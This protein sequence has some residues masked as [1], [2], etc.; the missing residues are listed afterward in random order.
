MS[1]Y[2]KV[3]KLATEEG[4]YAPGI[5]ARVR[6]LSKDP[7][8]KELPAD[9]RGRAI[10]R[11]LDSEGL[12]S[13]SKAMRGLLESETNAQGED[14]DNPVRFGLKDIAKALGYGENTGEMLDSGHGWE[15]IPYSRYKSKFGDDADAVRSILRSATHDYFQNEKTPKARSEAM[16]DGSGLGWL[17][18]FMFPRAAEA[19]L[20]GEDPSISKDFALDAAEIALSLVPFGKAGALLGRIP[21]IGEMFAKI[22]GVPLAGA[23]A[24]RLP[25]AAF[26]PVTTGALDA[27]AYDGEGRGTFSPSSALEATAFN[28][29]VPWVLDKSI[30]K[31]KQMRQF[32]GGDIE[33]G[34]AAGREG[35]ELM[36]K[37]NGE[38]EDAAKKADELPEKRADTASE[39]KEGT[40]EIAE[41]LAESP[42]ETAK[43]LVE[44]SSKAA[45]LQLGKATTKKFANSYGGAMVQQIP[46]GAAV[47]ESLRKDEEKNR[48]ERLKT[49]TSKKA[50][51]ALSGGDLTEEDKKFL[52]YVKEHPDSVVYGMPYGKDRDRFNTWLLTRGS[53]LRRPGWSA[54]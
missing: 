49:A 14:F 41:T 27:A 9:E 21:K 38:T 16:H 29:G 8:I 44:K 51:A 32:A 18:R 6:E 4:E 33:G 47:D 19:G 31:L 46:G 2:D 23:V 15:K 22:S 13:E 7:E 3:R 35:D 48:Q 11:T 17:A 39:A 1:V 43:D 40:E 34:K 42:K 37:I 52:A 53:F 20:R 36:K 54:E 45:A 30:G 10:L 5:R 50:E 12:L 26:V 28:L 25:D 24:R